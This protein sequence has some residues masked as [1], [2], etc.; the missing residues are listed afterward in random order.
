MGG[1]SGEKA[2][3]FIRGFA[4]QDC[5]VSKPA[6]VTQAV[7]YFLSA[8]ACGIRWKETVVAHSPLLCLMGDL[9][10]RP[11]QICH[12]GRHLFG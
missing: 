11:L 5:S 12:D 1:E 6:V 3:K 7:Y 2:L 4:R 10:S 9:K 8:I